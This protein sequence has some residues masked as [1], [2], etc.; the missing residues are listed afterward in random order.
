M[1]T[2]LSHVNGLC[3]PRKSHKPSFLQHA[4]LLIV[5]GGYPDAAPLQN[6]VA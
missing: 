4:R 6:P 3:Q 1:L 5:F 2:S